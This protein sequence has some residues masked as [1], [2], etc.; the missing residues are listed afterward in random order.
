MGGGGGGAR[1][2]AAGGS[3]FSLVLQTLV[4]PGSWV[5]K[6]DTVAE[7]DRQYMLTRLDDFRA[8]LEQTEASMGILKANLEV[9]R[10]AHAQSILVAK[11]A[12]DKARLDLKTVPVKGAI[13]S[14]TLRLAEEEAA[15]SYKQLLSEVPHKETSHAAQW[16]IGELERSESKVELARAEANA[17]TM[18]ARAPME[19]MTVMSQLMRG[20]QFAQIQQ[21]DS[22][23]PGQLYMR[24]VD[25]NSMVVNATVNQADSEQIRIGAKARVRFDAYPDLELP[26]HVYSIAAMPRSGGFRADYVKEVAVVL[27]LDKVEPRVIP[28]LS[29]SAD[30]TLTREENAVIAPRAA[31]FGAPGER[32]VFVKTPS[33]WEQQNVELGLASHLAVVVR[34]G[35]SAG[36]VVATESPLRQTQKG[37]GGTS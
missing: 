4:K 3:D 25:P 19:G 5:K 24:I 29:A 9:D 32:F 15:A 30:V 26:A 31:V 11:G 12:L 35:L 34:S 18:I 10:K 8:N 37:E 28:D 14:E 33:G 16:R 21:G 13:D 20:D 7:F 23:Y 6:G 22:L 2:G 1:I 27:K 36:Q 17:N